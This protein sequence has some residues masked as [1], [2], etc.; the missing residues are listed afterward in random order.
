LGKNILKKVNERETARIGHLLRGV[1]S[2]QIFDKLLTGFFER[3]NCFFEETWNII[4][5]C[6]SGFAHTH[7][8]IYIYIYIYTKRKR[9]WA[10]ESEN[11]IIS[12]I[13]GG[14]IIIIIIYIICT[15]IY[16]LFQ[17]IAALYVY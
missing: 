12:A 8:Y 1:N 14:I 7:I 5:I 10:R 3:C 15:D 9:E 17:G 6:I 16:A 2:W 13:V 11:T 4:V